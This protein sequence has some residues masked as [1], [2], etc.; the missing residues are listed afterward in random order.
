MTTAN[1]E[2]IATFGTALRSRSDSQV[3][4]LL[5]VRPDLAV[6]A[7]TSFLALAAAASARSSLDRALARLDA[8]H[9]TVCEAVV[10]LDP[11]TE[12]LAADHVAAAVGAG[13][14]TEHDVVRRAIDDLVTA[15]LLWDAGPQGGPPRLRPSPGLPELF[16]PYPAGLG[17]ALAGPSPTLAPE[18]PPGAVQ[19]VA[20]LAWGP[21][22]GVIPSSAPGRAAV[23]WLAERALVTRSDER[24]VV[25]GRQAA[26]ELRGGRTHRGVRFTAPDPAGRALGH[27]VVDGEAALAGLEAVRL[28]G[29]LVHRWVEEAPSPLRSG[30]LAVRDLRR[31][32]AD[33]GTD[34]ATA[35]LVVETAM[36]AGLIADDGEA[37]P[38][39][40]ATDAARAWLTEDIGTKWTALA[41]P[42][43][44][45]PRTPWLVGS[46]D[47][48]GSVRAALD[49]DLARSWVP[50]LRTQVMQA[51]A[52]TA[53]AR[54]VDRA[55]I[56]EVLR[57]RTPRL[58][59]PEQ[60][61]DGLLDGAEF[62]GITGAGALSTAGRTLFANPTDLPEIATAFTAM[63]APEVDDLLLQTDLTGVI[64]GRPGAELGALG[65]LAGVVESRG[66]A[67]TLR[68]TP[69][70]VA[71]A[72]E[73]MTADELLSGLARFSRVGVPQA[74]EY[75]VRDTARRRGSLRIGAASAYL[76]S[77]D[78]A[79]LA[80]LAAQGDLRS[81]G[82][83]VIA[84]TVLVASVPAA[85]VQAALREAGIAAQVEGPGGTLVQVP[86]QGRRATPAG[87]GLR[88]TTS[89]LSHDDGGESPEQ[90]AARRRRV[91]AGLRSA[92][93]AGGSDAAQIPDPPT[94]LALLREAI[95]DQSLLW[96]EI[97]GADGSLAR[98][99]LRPLTLEAGR[100]RA[101]DPDRE[102]EL[103][104]AIHRVASVQRSPS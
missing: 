53:P 32:A 76:R 89:E 93:A 1:A 91:I 29:A 58:V 16:G 23:R 2:D 69:E 96:V 33:L 10:A 13:P 52:D 9:L 101:L 35:V 84:P 94:L 6:P 82:L 25:L 56:V 83:T 48:R 42:W 3:D 40:V 34:E 77:D 100:L 74:L 22:V 37:F 43:R 14:G 79:L 7:P 97:I 15:A 81:L 85:Q 51:L 60:S 19:I 26:L 8:V 92:E 38:A 27:Q 61:V 78:V 102:A 95:A 98:R 90:T 49:P 72:L 87:Q 21:P 30:G 4:H 86:R 47:T 68:F 71:R 45:S 46:R 39:F 11:V 28:V 31:L 59:P 54:C 41:A 44:A 88:V 80:G 50:R 5:T 17:P 24:H 66:S 73:R 63:L 55:G 75:L 64:P 65:E 67:M 104:V 12:S 62:L 36:A 70:S 99:R 18:T 57:W 103:T 20:A